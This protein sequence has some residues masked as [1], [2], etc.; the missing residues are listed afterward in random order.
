MFDGE[1]PQELY[2]RLSALQVKLINLGDTHCDERWMKR[3]FVQV[4]LP[5]MK[6]TMNAIKQ[7]AGYKEM[8]ANDILQNII[9]MRISEKNA[10]GALACARGLRAPNIALK[11]KVSHYEDARVED[12]EEVM[13]GSAEDM[14]YAHTEHMAL[15]QRAFMK[16]WKSSSPSKP[17]SQ[18][19]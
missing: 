4:V 17:R 11:A 8:M 1:D 3:K 5:F 14:K 9:A 15:T 7:G 16:T 6:E 2:R 10:N 13:E 12:E 19:E 18:V